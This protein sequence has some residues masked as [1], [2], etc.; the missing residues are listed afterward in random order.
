M[1][2]RHFKRPSWNLHSPCMCSRSARIADIATTFVEQVFTT[3][4]ASGVRHMLHTHT[5]SHEIYMYI[6]H[7]FSS[8]FYIITVAAY[9]HCIKVTMAPPKPYYSYSFSIHAHI[10][11]AHTYTHRHVHIECM[12]P[13]YSEH[14]WDS[15]KCHYIK[16]AVLISGVVLYT[17]LL[18]WDHAWCP[19]WK[20]MSPFQG[21]SNRGVPLYIFLTRVAIWIASCT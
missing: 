7:Y 12:E 13:L 2:R 5:N 4:E 6:V 8:L 19:A 15:F 17:F 3:W 14:L 16:R 10:K 11:N 9:R 1:N 21:C 20:E 18:N